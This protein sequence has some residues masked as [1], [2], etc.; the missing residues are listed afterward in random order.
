MRERS[1]YQ[2]H[3][4]SK[5]FID[6][7]NSIGYEKVNVKLLTEAAGINRTTFYQFFSGKAELAEYICYTYLDKHNEILAESVCGKDRD[8]M[9]R[10]L[11]RAFDYI[12]KNAGAIRML[13]QIQEPTFSPY[14]VMQQSMS[15]TVIRVLSPRSSADQ[16]SLKLLADSFAASAMATIRIF[17]DND[18]RDKNLITEG[19][20][21]C[22]YDGMLTWLDTCK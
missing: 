5:C 14:V 18:C 22:C 7:V 11:D 3:N 17:I 13:W 6:L 16:L 4:L 19:I 10:M 12:E 9:L 2:V 20:C 15:D 8:S 21:C 1:D